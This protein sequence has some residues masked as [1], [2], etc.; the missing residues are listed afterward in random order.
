MEAVRVGTSSVAS[1]A[2]AASGTY[3]QGQDVPQWESTMIHTHTTITTTTTTHTHT[4]THTHI[5]THTHAGIVDGSL[6]I[7]TN[8]TLQPVVEVV[9]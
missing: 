3:E 6:D 1:L 4:H 2:A 5:H 8:K 9:V 7:V